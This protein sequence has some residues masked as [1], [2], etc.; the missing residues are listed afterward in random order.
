MSKLKLI[1]KLAI[2]VLVLS[3]ILAAAFALMRASSLLKTGKNI[4]GNSTTTS[5]VPMPVSPDTSTFPTAYNPTVAATVPKT[6]WRTYT[7]PE[8]GFM[9]EYPPEYEVITNPPEGEYHLF[10]AILA[11][12]KRPREN[13]SMSDAVAVPFGDDSSFLSVSILQGTISEVITAYSMDTYEDA[14]LE[15]IVLNNLS[16]TLVT[17]RDSF[18]SEFRNDVLFTLTGQR[19]LSIA[20]M[21]NAGND[22]AYVV[23]NSIFDTVLQ[24]VRPFQ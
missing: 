13:L 21:Q 5:D 19:V 17:S 12:T 15:D 24:S 14:V 18:S 23:P 4:P 2:V 11:H 20:Y 6:G 22:S 10:S 8:Y 3:V 9:F 16:G 7:N 1:L